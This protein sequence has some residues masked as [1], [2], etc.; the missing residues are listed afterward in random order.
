MAATGRLNAGESAIHQMAT[1]CRDLASSLQTGMSQLI[2]QVEDL[3]GVSLNG[4]ANV[5][6][7]GVSA[8]LD[9]GMRKILQAL[10]NLGDN[11]DRNANLYAQ[12][13]A[14]H[15]SQLKSAGT[16]QGGV[17]NVLIGQ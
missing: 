17:T 8:E 1:R 3:S 11:M 6:L 12:Q 10:N 15:A 4:S 16:I 13:D 9:D 14:D 5:A 2:T 7:Q